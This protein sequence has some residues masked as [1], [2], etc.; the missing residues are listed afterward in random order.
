MSKILLAI[1]L[2]F[3]VTMQS[4]SFFE[5][6]VSIFSRNCTKNVT[7]KYVFR[8]SAEASSPTLQMSQDKA[9][10]DARRIMLEQIDEYIVNSVSY[11][12]FLRD[13]KF[14]EK[15]DLMRDK[16]L[17]SSEISCSHTKKKSSG[18]TYSITIQINRSLVDDIISQYK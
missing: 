13:D 14:E 18:I 7:D 3:A 10:A 2:C 1:M 8:A 5:S 9:N 17:E 12:S 15:I 6:V 4:C 11:K 16:V